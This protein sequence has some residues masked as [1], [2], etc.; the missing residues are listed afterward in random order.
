MLRIVFISI[1][2]SRL[3]AGQNEC[4]ADNNKQKPLG[5]HGGI[6]PQVEKRRQR[7]E[8]RERRNN[9]GSKLNR[10]WTRKRENEPQIN[11][12]VRRLEWS[13]DQA[14]ESIITGSQRHY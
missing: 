9:P 4:Q 12:D 2:R 5:Q 6:L 3:T 1:R 7:R 8:H 10:E 11:A 14:L 13:A